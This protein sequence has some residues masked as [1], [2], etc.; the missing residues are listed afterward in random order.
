MLCEVNVAALDLGSNSFHLLV[1]RV[2]AL[3][4][5]EKLGSAKRTPRLGESVAATGLIPPE[6]FRTALDALGELATEARRYPIDRM[7]TVG[8]SAL[9][10]ADNGDDFVRAARARHG[11][12]VEL[13]SGTDE[14]RLVYEGARSR[15]EGVPRRA[16]VLDL[17]G[18]SLEVALGEGPGATLVESLPLGFLRVAHTLDAR[19]SV[20]A[21]LR[22]RV[23][24][25]VHT[26]GERLDERLRAALPEAWIFSGGM[27]RAAANLAGIKP[28]E[29][30]SR[31]TL[32]RLA[33][34]SAHLQPSQLV[35]LGV[36]PE[37]ARTF[38]LGITLLLAVTDLFRIPA[39]RVSPG[40]IREGLVLR[41]RFWALSELQPITAA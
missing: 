9:R 11:V 34:Q 13:L 26:L 8:T 20:D 19:G 6:A 10:D 29:P 5:I 17:G 28:G 39:L 31:A 25:H 27:A 30:M 21:E 33:D 2:G 24:E 22:A 23:F 18:G 36:A 16:A 40:G 1:A 4:R 32:E 38:A 3:G 14:G 41:E 7:V 35:G 12:H 37:R 15:L